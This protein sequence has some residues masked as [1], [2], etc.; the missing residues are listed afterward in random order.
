[1]IF[2]PG[3]EYEY[4]YDDIHLSVRAE[5]RNGKLVGRILNNDLLYSSVA[6]DLS[7]IDIY[8]HWREVKRAG[9]LDDSD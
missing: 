4:V 8:D 9:W 2:Q 6:L 1:M 5:M 3:H 7:K